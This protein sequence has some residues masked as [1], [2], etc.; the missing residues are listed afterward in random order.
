M[1]DVPT[2]IPGKDAAAN[3]FGTAGTGVAKDAAD[4]KPAGRLPITGQTVEQA[5]DSPPMMG[6]RGPKPGDP[7]GGV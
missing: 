6:Y 7:F 4:A 1:T 2:G 3:A 5:A